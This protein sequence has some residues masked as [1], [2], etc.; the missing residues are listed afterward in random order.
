M[1][2][3]DIP[4]PIA[5]SWRGFLRVFS[6]LAV[7]LIALICLFAWYSRWSSYEIPS[8][9]ITTPSIRKIHCRSGNTHA[10][11]VHVSGQINGHATFVTPHG[12]F[13][14]QPGD[15]NLHVGSDYYSDD[16]TLEYSPGNVTEGHL[17]VKYKFRT[18]GEI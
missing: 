8:A 13:E 5:I 14:L 7:I 4:P 11:E 16:A 12:E 10:L 18:I 2:D 3:D 1:R 15:V 6:I 9:E 17:V